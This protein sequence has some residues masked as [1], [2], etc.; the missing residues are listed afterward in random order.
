MDPEKHRR[1]TGVSNELILENLKSLAEAGAATIVRMPVIPG[2][3][4]DEVNI[5]A[6]GELVSRLNGVRRVDLLPYHAAAVNKYERLG[7]RYALV[8]TPTPDEEAVNRLAGILREYGL[9]VKIGG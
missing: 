9:Q 7:M 1:Y 2:I 5:R 3:N 8:D 6:V 4:D